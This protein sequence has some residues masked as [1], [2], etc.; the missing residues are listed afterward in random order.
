ML[1]R[2]GNL[3]IADHGPGIP[4]VDQVHLFERF[5]RGPWTSR[6]GSGLGLAIVGEAYQR[7][8]VTAQC[9]ST[10]GGGATFKVRLETA[11]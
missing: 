4:E 2:N 3:S 7:I 8:G 1:A 6:P 10:S 9:L 5:W 11:S